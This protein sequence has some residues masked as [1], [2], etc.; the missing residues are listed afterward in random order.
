MSIVVL[1]NARRDNTGKISNL[2]KQAMIQ[3][4]FSRYCELCSISSKVENGLNR[5]GHKFLPDLAEGQEKAFAPHCGRIANNEYEFKRS[6]SLPGK[7]ELENMIKG[8]VQGVDAEIKKRLNK[9]VSKP[10]LSHFLVVLFITI[11]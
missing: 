2:F 7:R 6:I 11:K 10:V 9:G 3:P 8:K 1:L 4:N 5:G